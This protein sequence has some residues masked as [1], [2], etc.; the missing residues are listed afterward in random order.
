ML[1]KTF[2]I[3][4]QVTEFDVHSAI[5]RGKLDAYKLEDGRVSVI[6]NEKSEAWSKKEKSDVLPCP[7]KIDE[8]GFVQDCWV[9]R[10]DLMGQHCCRSLNSELYAIEV[11]D[12]PT[13]KLPKL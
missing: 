2:A 8:D 10:N 13:S 5:K 12:L 9:F 6:E 7:S 1:V 3:L 4:K 11:E